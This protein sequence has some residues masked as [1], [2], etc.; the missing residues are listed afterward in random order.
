M[1]A[2]L[3]GIR[4]VQAQVAQDDVSLTITPEIPGPNEDVNAEI[5]SYT[6]DLNTANIT[7]RVNKQVRLSGIGETRFLFQTK[8]AGELVVLEVTIVI[9]GQTL[10]KTFQIKPLTVDLLW[11]AIDSYVPPF[12]KGK[13]LLSTEGLVRISAMPNFGNTSIDPKTLTYNWRRN[14]NAQPSASG[15][16]KR[17]ITIKQNYLNT[18]DTV[19][20]T[21]TN[22]SDGSVA[23]GRMNILTYKP[24]IIF[25]EKHPTLGILYNNALQDGVAVGTNDKTLVA[26]PY[27]VGTT[28]PRSSDLSYVWTLNGEEIPTPEKKNQIILRK[29][30]ESGTANLK[31][32]IESASKL[33]LELSKSLSINL[34]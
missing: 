22:N 1:W 20:T 14:Y 25:Y 32:M 7:W 24:K 13:A 10:V 18:D 11:Q 21:I 17:F 19:S 34:Q 28:F 15:Y 30:P 31:L 26:E 27:F 9:D 16:G 12:Y 8:N 4:T 23:V 33:F 3:F 5:K 6:Y 2:L 29:G